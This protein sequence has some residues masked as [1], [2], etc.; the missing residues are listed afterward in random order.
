MLLMWDCGFHS[1]EMAVKTR[2]RG[3]Q[4]LG[5]LPANVKPQFVR[6][7]PDGSYLAYLYSSDDRRRQGERL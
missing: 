7:L 4:F 3:S 5:R 2:Q 6:S 1:F